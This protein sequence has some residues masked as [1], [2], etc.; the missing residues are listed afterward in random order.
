[1]IIEPRNQRIQ[2]K[3]EWWPHPDADAEAVFAALYWMVHARTH[4][5]RSLAM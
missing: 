4:T 5:G 3:L 2:E 1:M